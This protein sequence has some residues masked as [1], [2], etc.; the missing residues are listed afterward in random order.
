M[1]LKEFI[2]RLN[3]LIKD[4]PEVNDYTVVTAKDEEGN[5]FNEVLYS[6]T[7]GTFNKEDGNYDTEGENKN[8][9]CLN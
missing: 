9:V 2:K 7:I 3:K 8:S 4:H 1:K 6:P 5:G